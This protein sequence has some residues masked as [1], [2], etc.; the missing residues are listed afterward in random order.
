MHSQNKKNVLFLCIDDLRPELASFGADYIISPNIDK[1]AEE[2]RAFHNHYV[3]SPSCGPSRFTML[4]GHYG[5]AG[6]D[7]IFKR[8]KRLTKNTSSVTPSMPEWFKNNGYTTISL[9]KVSHHPGGLGGKNWDDPNEIE[10]PNAW[11]KSLMPVS[12]WQHPRGAMHG[13]ANGEIRGKSKTMSVFQSTEGEDTIYPDGHITNKALEQL[14]KLSKS[15]KPFFFAVGLIRPHLPFGAPKKYLDLYNDIEIPKI[16]HP[17]KPTLPS[18]WH[19]SGEFFRYNLWGKDP[20]TDEDFAQEV[21]KHYA[22]CVS[23]ADAQVGK[24]ITKLKETGQYKNTIIVLWG[25]HG[26]NLGDHNIWGKHNLFEEA[27]RSPLIISHPNLKRKGKK[28]NAIVES[29]DIFP[30][31]CELANLPKPTFVNGTSLISNL[32]NPKKKGHFAYAYNG[33]GKTIR[34]E[35][36][37]FTLLKKGNKELYDHKNDP[38]E[39]ENIAT[40]KPKLVKK[41]TLLINTKI[42]QNKNQIKK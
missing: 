13:L 27:L 38:Y 26:W 24:I 15:N 1:L 41:L 20:R 10:M 29:V 22:A 34:T 32:K 18:T 3:N 33:S 36:Y 30:T 7:A 23:Y 19:K 16:P 8:A 39:T 31:L 40:E 12:E 5:I 21:R 37:R 28:T 2:G 9:G 14:E 42:D 25:D 4:T 6:N 17:E 11:D 35:R